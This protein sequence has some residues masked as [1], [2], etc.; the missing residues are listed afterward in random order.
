MSNTYRF[1]TRDGVRHITN[2]SGGPIHNICEN[3]YNWGWY[4]NDTRIAAYDILYLE[5]GPKTAYKLYE[6]FARN[7]L[8][9]IEADEFVLTSG[10]IDFIINKLEMELPNDSLSRTYSKRV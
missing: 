6:S 4:G 3:C 7:Y 9:N 8:A 5:Y 1:S 10:A 2:A